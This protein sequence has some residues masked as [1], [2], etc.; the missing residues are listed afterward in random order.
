MICPQCGSSD[1]RISRHPHVADVFQ[2]IRGR[3][4][5]R[6][7]KCR[8]RFYGALAAGADKGRARKSTH[9]YRGSLWGRGGFQQRRRLFRKALF[10]AVFAAAFALFW[11]FL[12]FI[13]TD[14]MPSEDYFPTSTSSLTHGRPLQNS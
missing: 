8:N 7:R 14:R 3:E 2:R 6:C 13:S 9:Q 1:I 5:Y 10:F 4:A 12:R 11:M